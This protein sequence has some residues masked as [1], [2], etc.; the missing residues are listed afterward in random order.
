MPLGT[1]LGR[2]AGGDPGLAELIAL[3]AR[4]RF[5]PAGPSPGDEVRLTELAASLVAR[6]RRRQAENG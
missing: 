2:L 4:L 6:W 3:H 5:D 1:W